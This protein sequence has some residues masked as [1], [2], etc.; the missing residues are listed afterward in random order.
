MAVPVVRDL[1]SAH[2]VFDDMPDRNLIFCWTCLISGYAKLGSSEDALNLFTMMLDE[3][4]LPESDTMVEQSRVNFDQISDKGKRSIL[5]WNLAI[6][7]IDMYSKCGNLDATR[8]IFAEI[9]EKDVVSFN[10]MI[11]GLA[12][13]GKGDEALRLFSEMQEL[14]LLL[15]DSGTFLGALSAWFLMDISRKAI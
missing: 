13:N 11:V 6:A 8:E 7:L 9:V 1:R 4:L 5:S 2:Q 10:A 3:N 15:P 12:V 14:C